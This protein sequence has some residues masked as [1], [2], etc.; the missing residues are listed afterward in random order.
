MKT[1]QFNYT[2]II[3]TRNRLKMLMNCL[4]SFAELAPTTSSFE[5]IVVDD[6]STIPVKLGQRYYSE[7]P[8]LRIISIKHSGPGEARNAGAK[9]ARSDYLVFVDDDCEVDRRFI[10]ELDRAID[11]S[12]AVMI[13]GKVFNKL[14]NN[15]FSQASQV[16]VN[17]AYRFYNE[18]MYNARMIASN[19][20]VVPREK[21]LE[22]SG[23]SA[24][25]QIAS[26]DR[27]FC[28]RWQL[29]GNT[30]RYAPQLK[31]YHLHSL[32]FRTFF[33]QHFRYGRGAWSFRKIQQL[34]NSSNFI[35]DTGFY[36]RIWDLLSPDLKSLPYLQIP[37]IFLLL[38]TWQVANFAGFFYQAAIDFNLLRLKKR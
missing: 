36:R 7:L 20:M 2:F 38:G 30:I 15:P 3:P 21:F 6:G 10:I 22:L 19:C 4:R 26:E 31:V 5:I 18:D 28:D 34:R 8:N 14:V 32:T 13:G 29:E 17:M 37:Q 11:T 9:Y 25:L 33:K 35:K 27:E 12:P 1:D 23:F 16:I 24:S